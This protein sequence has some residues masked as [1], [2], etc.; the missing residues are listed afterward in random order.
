MQLIEQLNCGQVMAGAADVYPGRV[1]G[2]RRVM[3]D[4]T[5][6]NALLG[7]DISAGDM[8]ATLSRVGINARQHASANEYEAEIPTFRPD[9][10]CEADIAEEIARFFGYNNV[11][12]IATQ[13]VSS[14]GGRSD[15]RE[16]EDAAA[17]ALLGLG[18]YEAL[19]FPFESPKVFDKLMIPAD[20]TR[21][22]NA[23][24]ISNPLGEDFSIMR[25]LPLDG[26]LT[27]LSRNFNHRNECA[28]LFELAY[29]YI[30]QEQP[31]TQLPEQQAVL[32]L[33]AYDTAGMDFFD[34][35]GDVEQ[36]LAALH[37]KNRAYEAD[38][39]PFTHPGRTARIL[40]GNTHIGCVGEL[41]PQVCSHYQINT[42]VYLAMLRMDEIHRLAAAYTPDFVPLPK[43]PSVQRDLAF[44]VKTTV[45][46]A[47]LDLA[48]REWAGPLLVDVRLFDVYQGAQIEEGFK[49]MAYSLRF[50]AAD[51]T[52]TD[53]D[54]QKPLGKILRR[55]QEKCGAQLRE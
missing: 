25:T 11:Q 53:D 46:A 33:A 36:L 52:L 10:A 21:W 48:I 13:A 49:S 15:K 6:V 4:P 28:R 19:T 2:S 41:H 23:I 43:F 55:L 29:R 32:T 16:R 3:Y 37:I 40:A 38:A 50:R 18:Y 44:T 35:K 39:L 20:D 17:Q 12:S 27:S 45:S 30:L 8:T 14:S 31:L 22:R 9:I 7:T 5:R 42:R 34:I 1:D 24:S 47:E 54:V 26:L 51:R